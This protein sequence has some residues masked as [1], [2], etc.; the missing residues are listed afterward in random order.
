[1]PGLV[2]GAYRET[3]VPGSHVGAASILCDQ[4]QGTES[5]VT[6]PASEHAMKWTRDATGRTYTATKQRYQAL[7]WSTSTGEWV[8][9]ISQNN[10]A[11]AHERCS[12]LNDAKR[13]CE[14]QLAALLQSRIA[15]QRHV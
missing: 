3:S 13:W 1:M 11:I 9:M 8:A 12:R 2:L 10:I 7:V 5:A 14:T 15:R 4:S 6:P